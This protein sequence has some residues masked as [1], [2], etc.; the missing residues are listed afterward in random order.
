MIFYGTRASNIHNGQIINIDCPHCETNTS[1]IYSVFG[2]Y[3]HIYWIPFFP[4]GKVTIAE[5]NNCKKTFENKELPENIKTKL[6]REKEKHPAK[7]PVWMFSGLFIIATFASILV[8]ND[9]QNEIAEAEFIKNPKAGDVYYLKL[10]EKHYTTARVDEATRTELY[11]T[12]ND[13]EIDLESDIASIDEAKNY[14]VSKD[15]IN[16]LQIQEAFKK[17][18]IVSIIRN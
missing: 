12:N 9:N 3:A 5:C 13:Y 4:I 16:V 10:S 2:K 17:D 1:M 14:T 15:T 6:I 8:Y 11:L 7:T 18:M